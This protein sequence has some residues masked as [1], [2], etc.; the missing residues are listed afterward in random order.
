VSGNPVTTNADS[1]A[2]FVGCK[3]TRPARS[4][5]TAGGGLTPANSASFNLVS[6][7]PPA[8]ALGVPLAQTFGGAILGRNPAATVD[9]VTAGTGNLELP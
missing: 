6:G 7:S 3:E 5:S 9:D 8:S 4:R 1:I 2:V